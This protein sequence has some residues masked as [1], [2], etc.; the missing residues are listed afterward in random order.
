MKLQNK[1]LATLFAGALL[2]G[3]VAQAQDMTFFRIGDR[4]R[5]RNLFPDRWHYCQCDF[6]S[7]GFPPLRQG[8]QLRRSWTGRDCAVDKRLGA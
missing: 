1:F 7:A 3:G 8:R 5:R 6:Q 2:A 4:Q